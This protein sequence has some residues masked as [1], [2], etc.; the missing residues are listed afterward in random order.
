MWNGRTAVEEALQLSHPPEQLK[1]DRD[2]SEDSS[3]NNG[4]HMQGS[5]V[6][7]LQGERSYAALFLTH[8]IL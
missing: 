7:R 1:A 6:L 8:P 3:K 4:M 5:L 2:L